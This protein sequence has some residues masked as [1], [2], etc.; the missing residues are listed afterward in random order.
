MSGR[1][2]FSWLG[3]CSGYSVGSIH[4]FSVAKNE[5]L[6]QADFLVM[7]PIFGNLGD[8]ISRDGDLT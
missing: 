3:S 1:L 6:S 4:V 7:C 2:G 5:F 8:L